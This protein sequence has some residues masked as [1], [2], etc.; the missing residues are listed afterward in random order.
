MTILEELIDYAEMCLND[1]RISE[2]E[3]YISC[4]AH[5]WACMR[6]LDDIERSSLSSCSFRW[7]ER[8]ARLIVDW[9]RLLRHSKGV[10][11][12]KPIELTKW[13]KFN[14]CQIY[15]WRKKSDGRR[16]FKKS[17]TE[18]ARKNAK[19]QMEAGVALYESSVTASKNGEVA[20]V[21]TAGT[22][23]DQS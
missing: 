14:L 20:E 8:E 1:V 17:F 23:R 11:A 6:F 19:S 12:K 15:G 5:K 3:D 9:F 4:K 16:R 22:K 2:N 13:Q 7:D 10:L 21:Y 18:V